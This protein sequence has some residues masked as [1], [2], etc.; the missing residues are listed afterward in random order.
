MMGWVPGTPLLEDLDY[1]YWNFNVVAKIDATDY[2]GY[3]IEVWFVS[4]EDESGTNALIVYGRDSLVFA[5]S[6]L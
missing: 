4:F 5:F 2:E 1:S 3:P 6:F